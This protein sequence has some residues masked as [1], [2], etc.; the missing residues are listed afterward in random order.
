MAATIIELK[1]V[2][3]IYDVGDSKVFAIDDVSLKI[4]EGEFVE[5]LGASGSGK[6]TMMNLIGCLDLPTK[7]NIFLDGHDISHFSESHL[8]NTRGKRIGF[9]FQTF[10]LI[11]TMTVVGNIGLP[12]LFQ[13]VPAQERE[14]KARN[15]AI[16][17]GLEHRLEHRPNELS[18][19]ERQR[20]SMARALVADPKI[21]IA[22]E[23]TGNLDSKTGKIVMER[24]KEINQQGKTVIVVTH[25]ADLTC[26]A[27]RVIYLKDGKIIKEEGKCSN[28]FESEK[29][30]SK[31]QGKSASKVKTLSSKKSGK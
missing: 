7:G 9:V 3:K 19:G 15:L 17:F 23:P 2:S 12:L 28:P 21:I 8:A 30:A 11:P 14:E 4:K 1:D 10:N 13:G 24:L 31:K 20:V 27:D 22:D 16:F 6:S 18:G 25:D 29:T 5:I 26:Y